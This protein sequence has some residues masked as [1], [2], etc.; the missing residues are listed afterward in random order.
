[1]PVSVCLSVCPSILAPVA[2]TGG[3]IG[4]SKAPLEA[5]ERLKDDGANCGAI[6]VT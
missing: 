4:A 1:M 5:P 2:R 3:R 6:A